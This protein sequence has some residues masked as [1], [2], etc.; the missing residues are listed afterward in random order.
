MKTSLRA[1]ATAL[2]ISSAA[3]VPTRLVAQGTIPSVPVGTLSTSA[4]VVRAGTKPTLTWNITYPS[5]VKDYVTVT[6]PSTVT[7]KQTLFVDIRVLGAGVTSAQSGSSSFTYVPTEA[8][9]KYDNSSYGRVFYGTN[10][11]VNP[12]RVVY[13]RQ[14]QA[15]KSLRFGGR[16]FF[17][18]AWGPTYTT[19]TGTQNVRTLVSGD[20]PPSNLPGYNAPSLE[21]FL[22]PYLDASGKVKIGPMD[23]IV[24]MEL[25]HTDS[26]RT[27]PGYDLQDMVLLVTF[28]TN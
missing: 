2:L 18:N 24:Y 14:V 3:L 1:A 27:D 13:T 4:T 6:P 25:T 16:Y 17:N 7:P 11:D 23:V 15:G 5:V 22:K 8:Q 26:Q 19:D 12:N 10:N 9:V 21:S 28:R 20:T